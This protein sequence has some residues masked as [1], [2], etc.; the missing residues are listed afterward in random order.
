MLAAH[1]LEPA[2]SVAFAL[3]SGGSGTPGRTDRSF[4][5]TGLQENK[6]E[7]GRLPAFYY[8][9]EVLQPELSN[10]LLTTVALSVRPLPG[11]RLG[12]VHHFYAQH[13][14]A[15]E[16]DDIDYPLAPDGRRRALGHGV[17]LILGLTPAANLSLDLA[18]GAF[19]PGAAF[20]SSARRALAGRFELEYR[21]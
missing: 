20:P 8:Y 2:L 4:Q 15:R 3:A 21:F 7:L 5:A 1:H 16:H 19:L 11:V 6:S 14:A 12:L 13:R 17:D 9:G 10:L 18:V